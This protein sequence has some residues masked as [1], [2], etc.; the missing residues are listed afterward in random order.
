MDAHLIDSA[1]FGHQW[2]T[3]ESRGIFAETARVARW[4]DVIIA[5]AEAQ[6]D[7]GIIP[8][9]SAAAIAGLRGSR[10]DLAGIAAGTRTTSHSTLGLIQ[11]LQ[12]MLPADAAEHVYYGATVQDISDTAQVLEI[13]EVAGLVWRDLWAIEA[14]L[15]ALA[16]RHRDDADGWSYAR[17]AGG[18]DHLRVQ[19]RDV[20][21]RG[22]S[23]PGAP[24]SGPRPL[25]GGGAGRCGRRTR[26]LRRAGD[27][28]AYGVLRSTRSRGAGHLL[29]DHARSARGV[30]P[31][32]GRRG[33][34]DGPDR[35]RG[36]RARPGRARR[37]ARAVAVEH[38]GQ[39]LDAAQAQSRGVRA[40]RHARPPGPLVGGR[41]RGDDDRRARAG[42]TSP[43]RPSG[44]CCR[45]SATTRWP[46]PG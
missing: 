37:G 43:G 9:S 24:S 27:P 14:E 5:L 34:R 26:V 2:S 13:A 31:G 39:H 20:G 15:L 4:V 8:A 44:S 22:R 1:I 11:V 16:E 3:A 7:V 17:S 42:R 40:G 38:G 33:Q 28:A 29:A 41:A 36:L 21:R 32:A 6:A 12:R 18:S 19:G 23:Q 25:A 10:L 45:S 46:R 35:E 30:R